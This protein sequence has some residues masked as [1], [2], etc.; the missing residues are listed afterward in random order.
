MTIRWPIHLLLVINEVN[1][2]VISLEDCE[3]FV[4]C[5]QIP[6]TSS[7]TPVDYKL[8]QNWYLLEVHILIRTHAG[9]KLPV[10]EGL[11]TFT[12]P[13][14]SVNNTRLGELNVGIA[15]TNLSNGVDPEI[16][17]NTPL[18]AFVDGPMLVSW[19]L[20]LVIAKKFNRS[21]YSLQLGV[22]RDSDDDHQL[23]RDEG[24]DDILEDAPSTSQPLLESGRPELPRRKKRHYNSTVR[25]TPDP[26]RRARIEAK[27]RASVQTTDEQ[28]RRGQRTTCC[29]EMCCRKVTLEV[30]RRCRLEYF[31]LPHDE[32]E[33]YIHTRLHMRHQTAIEEGKHIIDQKL[34]CKK[35]FWTIYGFS[36]SKYYGMMGQQSKGVVRG[37]H[38][39]QRRPKP[40]GNSIEADVVLRQLLG[41]LAEPMPHMQY[42]QADGSPGMLTHGR[43]PGAYCHL[44]VTGLWPGDPNFTVSSLARC[45]RDL[46]QMDDIGDHIGDLARTTSAVPLFTSLLDQAAFTASLGR[47]GA[48]DSSFLPFVGNGNMQSARDNVQRPPFKPLPPVFM[49]QMDN[50]AKDNKNIHVLAFCSELVIRGVFETV[51]V[52]FLMV[53]HTHEDVDALFLKP[54]GFR[55][56]MANNVSIY[57][58][59]SKVDGP[60]V[61]DSGSTLWK[62]VD[63]QFRFPMGEPRALKLPGS[64]PRISEVSSFIDNLTSHLQETF[65]DPT[66]ASYRRYN[67]VIS[68]WKKVKEQLESIQPLEDENLRM[69]FWPQTNHGTGFTVAQRQQEATRDGPEDGII[70]VDELQQELHQ[71][72]N[73]ML[74][75]Y[76]GDP[77]NRPKRSFIPLEDIT[78][79]KFVIL[80]PDDAFEAEIPRMIW[81]GQAMGVVVREIDDEHHGQFLVEWWRPKHRKSNVTN[82]ERYLNVL[83][84]QKDWEKDLGYFTPEWINATA[85]VYSWK[86]RSK[87]GVPQNARLNPLAKAAIKSH[88]QQL[89]KE[90]DDL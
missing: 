38:G 11:V 89:D 26:L 14:A 54:L 82:K 76:V 20:K 29:G 85:V 9:D 72:N 81:L 66:S 65:R 47:Q 42:I 45:L 63:G 17:R 7:T 31:G 52:N 90:N 5:S 10:A 55:F 13:A 15:V 59:Q 32:R 33:E 12:A 25:N 77:A 27:K 44:S 41:Q 61:P 53:G 43:K 56:S 40:R 79:G 28:I 84:G 19:S 67:P 37:Y 75:P 6:R 83:A 4:Q 48:T 69:G 49:L 68:Y 18:A 50:S 74:Q 87:E 71:E 62:K 1:N 23:S 73:L 57:K 60:W 2:D 8:R 22:N 34:I 24:V 21:L 16:L 80:R 3:G 70:V 35:A 36:K 64:H 39:N 88:F 51:E 86:Y 58:Y 30:I 78:E 46:E